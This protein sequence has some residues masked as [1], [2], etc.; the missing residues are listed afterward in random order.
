MR[1]HALVAAGQG[2][3]VK[4]VETLDDEGSVSKLKKNIETFLCRIVG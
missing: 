1:D 2:A 3:A 4:F